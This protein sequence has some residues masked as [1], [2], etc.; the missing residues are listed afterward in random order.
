MQKDLFSFTWANTNWVYGFRPLSV[1]PTFHFYGCVFLTLGL[2]EIQGQHYFANPYRL[3]D[4]T[5][6]MY[7]L[8]K[9]LLTFYANC[10]KLQLQIVADIPLDQAPSLLKNNCGEVCLGNFICFVATRYTE[11]NTEINNVPVFEELYPFETVKHER[12]RMT[13]QGT[14]VV[15]VVVCYSCCCCWH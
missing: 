15:V 5:R 12:M 7:L 9:P 10:W 13:K 3:D 4:V 11:I 1:F 8:G 14:V 6:Q 2:C